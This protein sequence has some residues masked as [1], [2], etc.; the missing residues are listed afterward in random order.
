MGP[1]AYSLPVASHSPPC[2]I[3]MAAAPAPTWQLSPSCTVH[4]GRGGGEGEGG[5][6]GGGGDGEGGGGE[7]E[8]GGG[9]GEGGGHQSCQED[10]LSVLCGQQDALPSVGGWA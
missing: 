8:G 2:E 5:G 10:A 6:E 4:S 3:G 9:E 1:S 7:G